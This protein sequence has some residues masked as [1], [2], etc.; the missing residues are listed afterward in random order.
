VRGARRGR[1]E[2]IGSFG[3]TLA[4]RLTAFVVFEPA[5]LGEIVRAGVQSVPRAQVG[6]ARALG[7]PG[8]ARRGG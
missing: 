5:C 8:S 4:D 7:P 1:V 3:L 2:L 6:A